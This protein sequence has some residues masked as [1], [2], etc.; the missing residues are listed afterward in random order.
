MFCVAQRMMDSST[1]SSTPKREKGRRGGETAPH[2]KSRKDHYLTSPYFTCTKE[3]RESSTTQEEK[4]APHRGRMDS[5]T[6]QCSTIKKVRRRKNSTTKKGREN[7]TLPYIPYRTALLLCPTV[8]S[9]HFSFHFSTFYF[10]LCFSLFY[11]FH[12]L[13]YLLCVSL[14]FF[15]F[16]CYYPLFYCLSSTNQKE[17]GSKT[18]PPKKETLLYWNKKGGRRRQHQPR[19]ESSTTSRKDGQQYHPM[20]HRPK[21]GGEGK[22]H[23]QKKA[24]RTPLYLTCLTVLYFYCAVL[25]VPF[26]FLFIFDFFWLFVFS[27][28]TLPTQQQLRRHH[29]HTSVVPIH[30]YHTSLWPTY[31]S[32]PRTGLSGPRYVYGPHSQIFT[33]TVSHCRQ[34]WFSQWAESRNVLWI[35]AVVI[36][37]RQEQWG[38]RIWSASGVCGRGQARRE[39]QRL[40]MRHGVLNERNNDCAWDMAC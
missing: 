33:R 3:G 11:F 40:R 26:T 37:M 36:S 23:H 18:S 27:L 28:F 14:N 7:T 25:Y 31:T 22:L 39:Q 17:R 30:K 1:H 20:Q 35:V 21:R 16:T 29:T 13:L 32:A 4:A 34:Y 10:Y 12:C 8:F 24:R 9:F 19:G 38:C 6:T 5:S 15:L 2:K